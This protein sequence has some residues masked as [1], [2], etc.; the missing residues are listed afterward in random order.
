MAKGTGT[1]SRDGTSTFKCCAIHN[2]FH[3]ISPFFVIEVT[4]DGVDELTST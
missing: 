4:P 2:I 3:N 1:L